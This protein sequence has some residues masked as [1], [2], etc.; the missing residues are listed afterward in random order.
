MSQSSLSAFESDM[1]EIA[2][3]VVEPDKLARTVNVEL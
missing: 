1:R 2:I 3:M